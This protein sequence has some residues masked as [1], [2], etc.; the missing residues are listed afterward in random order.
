[1]LEDPFAVDRKRHVVIVSSTCH[2]PFAGKPVL[3]PEISVEPVL[4]TGEEL[5]LSS[6]G[7]RLRRSEPFYG[8]RDFS[9]YP[10]LVGRKIPIEPLPAVFPVPPHDSAAGLYAAWLYIKRDVLAQIE[11]EYLLRIDDAVVNRNIEESD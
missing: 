6:V 11:A 7:Q 8:Y 2:L 1:M 3:D 9:Q 5:F 4:G 10:V